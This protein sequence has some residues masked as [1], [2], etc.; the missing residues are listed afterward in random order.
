MGLVICAIAV[1]GFAL[2]MSV[3]KAGRRLGVPGFATN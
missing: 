1:S 2:G 3:V